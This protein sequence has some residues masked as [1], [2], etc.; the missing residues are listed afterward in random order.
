M[1]D[2]ERK[3]KL[4][5]AHSHW[6]IFL[7]ASSKYGGKF[8]NR[9]WL[10]EQ[11]CSACRAAAPSAVRKAVV[12]SSQCLSALL[13]I[14][15]QQTSLFLS[16]SLSLAQIKHCPPGPLWRRWEVLFHCIKCTFDC[17]PVNDVTISLFVILLLVYFLKIEKKPNLTLLIKTWN[18][19]QLLCSVLWFVC[20]WASVFVF[21]IAH[22]AAKIMGWLPKECIILKI[23]RLN[24]L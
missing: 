16:V 17:N 11:S 14:T 2:C 22:C 12:H 5:L 13:F 15:G 19:I 1:C 18:E 9:K 8:S 20:V 7:P 24:T 21:L 3:Y 6:S 4:A 10:P 23:Y